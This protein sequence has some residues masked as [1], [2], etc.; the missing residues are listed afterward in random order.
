MNA[1]DAHIACAKGYLRLKRPDD[2]LQELW[3]IEDRGDDC[4][5]SRQMIVGI[6][7]E[8]EA[9]VDLERYARRVISKTRGESPTGWIGL[10][11]SYVG[12]NALDSALAK[13]NM[14]VNS[15]PSCSALWFE[16]ARIY[17]LMGNFREADETLAIA[18]HL[19]SHSMALA[20]AEIDFIPYFAWLRDASMKAE[21]E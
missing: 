17:V 9:W 20:Q 8:K 15:C 4:E 1:K 19:N 5:Q 16:M 14:A 6:L 18:C 11:Y 13:A 12:R 3:E 7:L 10:I 2:A 21:E